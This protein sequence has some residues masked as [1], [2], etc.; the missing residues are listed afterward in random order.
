[1]MTAWHSS[2]EILLSPKRFKKKRKNSRT[3]IAKRISPRLVYRTPNG[4]K[5]SIDDERR[6]IEN[7]IYSSQK[8]EKIHLYDL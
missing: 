1:M 5:R 3:D 6:S 7:E 8:L 2:R 4:Q